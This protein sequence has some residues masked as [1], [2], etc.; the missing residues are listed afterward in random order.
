M[1]S[2]CL[3]TIAADLRSD[4]ISKSG[5]AT[6]TS[7]NRACRASRS[8]PPP[9]RAMHRE[10][11]CAEP[12]FGTPRACRVASCCKTSRCCAVL[13]LVPC[14]SCAMLRQPPPAASA[15]RAAHERERPHERRADGH[16]GCPLLENERGAHMVLTMDLRRVRG[17]NLYFSGSFTCTTGKA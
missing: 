15:A 6:I 4:S 12:S 5:S 9:V 1:S 3:A 17:L 16:A 2:S 7:V 13:Q 14:T 10:H 11:V 8:L